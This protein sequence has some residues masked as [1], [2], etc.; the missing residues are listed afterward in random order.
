MLAGDQAHYLIDQQRKILNDAA[1]AAAAE[2]AD[3]ANA[4]NGDAIRQAATVRDANE[5]AS[6]DAA[7]R[8]QL[9]QTGTH[10]QK[11]ALLKAE[12]D[13]QVQLTGA[14][15]KQAIEA[16]TA[17]I[18]ERQ[19]AE[20]AAESAATRATTELGKQLSLEERIRDSKEQQLSATLDAS[21]AVIRDRQ[22]R[23]EEDAGLKLAESRLANPNL[24]ADQRQA[25]Q[26]TRDLILIS[27]QQRALAIR[28]QLA[29]AGGAIVGGR[30][31]QSHAGAL[32]A[33]GPSGGL[34][35]LPPLGALGGLGGS[36]GG[37]D[38][39]VTLD[40]QQIAATVVTRLRGG[41]AQAGSAGAGH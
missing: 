23:R 12:Y 29:T 40:G 36:A 20:S 41:L 14:S 9:L 24:T 7:R 8:Q 18:L 25:V 28:A 3:L 2:T 37:V 32:P 30:I 38:V 33:L 6:A 19:A 16:Q 4:T 22:Q 13:R 26:D 21:S 35:S 5:R 1:A 27:Q 39:F 10:Q 17:L 34:P 11:I 31:L 15:S